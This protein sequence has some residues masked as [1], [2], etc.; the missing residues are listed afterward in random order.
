[1]SLRDFHWNDD[2]RYH[3]A[4][5]T[6][7]WGRY[8][9]PRPPPSYSSC[10]WRLSRPP[11][12]AWGPLTPS[13]GCPGSPGTRLSLSLETLCWTW[14]TGNTV[15]YKCTLYSTSV[16]CTVQVQ[17]TLVTTWCPRGR[18]APASC[19]HPDYQRQHG[20]PV[21]RTRLQ[22][23][24]TRP[25]LLTSLSEMELQLNVRSFSWISRS[26]KVFVAWFLTLSGGWTL[27]RCP[28]PAPARPGPG[29]RAGSPSAPSRRRV[30][31]ASGIWNEENI[32]GVEVREI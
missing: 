30:S 28:A 31:G 29:R 11:A 19:W 12:S 4:L 13:V 15:Q 16:H 17:G 23:Y 2:A 25:R 5:A 20:R 21:P 14:Q 6:S 18:V 9:S 3:L 27:A 32:I 10:S 22:S 26:S 7:L 1:M 8:R 24:R